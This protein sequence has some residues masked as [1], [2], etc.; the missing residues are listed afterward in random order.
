MHQELPD[1]RINGAVKVVAAK[2]VGNK[3]TFITIFLG[4]E[5]EMHGHGS[6]D[7]CVSCSRIAKRFIVMEEA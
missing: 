4:G 6:Q 2:S 1:G 7:L 5:G 3:G